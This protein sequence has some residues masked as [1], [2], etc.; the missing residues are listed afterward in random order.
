MASPMRPD[1]D[2]GL[3]NEARPGKEGAEEGRERSIGRE[4]KINRREGKDINR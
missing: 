3:S 1:Q 4:G 2:S